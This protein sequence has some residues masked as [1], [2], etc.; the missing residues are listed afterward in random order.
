MFVWELSGCGFESRCCHLNF[1][2]SAYFEQ[3]VLWHSG[4][5]WVQIHSETRT[6]HDNKHTVEKGVVSFHWNHL[7]LLREQVDC[8]IL[9]L[10]V[11][12]MLYFIKWPNLVI[13]TS[14]DI[15][16]Y[17]YCNYL[18]PFEIILRFRIKLFSYMRKKAS[19]KILILSEWKEL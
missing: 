14:R 16:Q 6:R 2:Y 8:Y 18:L 1:R 5:Y 10:K 7:K 11:F 12:L 4:N 19:S 15:G 13:F 3:G 17:V 9:I